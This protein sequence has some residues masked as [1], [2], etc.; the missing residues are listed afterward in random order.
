GEP[1]TLYS[2]RRDGEF[3]GHAC[4]TAAEADDLGA[5]PDLATLVQEA[6]RRLTWP[7]SAVS[8][9]PPSG[10]TLVNFETFF[11]TANSEPTVQS[12]RLLGQQVEV[13][14]SP[15]SYV[16]HFGDG[17]S[18]ESASAGAAYPTGD[19]THSFVRAGTVSPSV[20]TTYR[21]RWRLNGGAWRDIDQTLTVVGTPGDLRVVEAR[22]ELVVR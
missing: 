1:G 16:W 6:F 12:V 11:Y 10:R 18:E 13:E 19:I 9:D 21:G 14:A 7:S 5:G 2:V 3:V 4:L 22:P 8:V 17:E 15:V 20:D